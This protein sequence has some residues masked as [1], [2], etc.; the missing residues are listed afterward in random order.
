MEIR[1][2][3]ATDK[4]KIRRKNED[5]FVAERLG[6]NEYVFAVADGM[7]GHQAGE[8]ASRLAC[9]KFVECLKKKKFSNPM[10]FFRTALEE[11][12]KKIL[13]EASK[14]IS[15][16]GMG[17]T[18]SV[19]YIKGNQAY[20]AHVGDSRIYWITGRKIVQL[21]VDHSLVEKLVREGALSVEEARYH[22]KRNVLYQS[23]G[24][25][26]EL[27]P[28]LVGPIKLRPG[29]RF[30]LCSDGLFN[31]VKDFEIKNTVSKYPLKEALFKMI[32]LA[33][34][35]GGQD[36]I[37]AIVVEVPSRA[38]SE[39]KKILTLPSRNILRKVDW[40]ALL[41]VL[42][43]IAGIFIIAF[44]A[45]QVSKKYAP[46]IKTFIRSSESVK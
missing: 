18:L 28:Q 32:A 24:V 30:V 17:S 13:E 2:L 14:D 19:L 15:K 46:E 38:E 27:H 23:L 9:E 20:I 12:N 21:T 42:L 3:G 6:E 25:S 34:E 35:R 5:F 26:E 11:V 1:Y 45:K 37:T 8:V 22:P 16:A 41:F 7:G 33:N 10:L 29:D 31:N 39:S 40:K 43:L 4:G 44:A 36:N